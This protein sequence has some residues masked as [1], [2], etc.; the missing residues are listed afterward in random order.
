[1]ETGLS[2]STQ[3]PQLKKGTDQEV[4]RSAERGK[5][6]LGKVLHLEANV[7][8]SSGLHMDSE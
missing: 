2:N 8:D 5:R 4:D 3:R 7:K 6:P 1:M